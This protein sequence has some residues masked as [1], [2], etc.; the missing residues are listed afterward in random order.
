MGTFIGWLFGPLWVALFDRSQATRQATLLWT[1]AVAVE[2]QFPLVPFLEAL[3]DEAGGRWR[4]KV[5]GLADLISAGVSIPDALEAIPGILPK[6]AVA[7]VRVGAR[8]GNMAGALREAATLARRRSENTGMRFQGTLL[9]LCLLFMVLGTITTFVMIW[10]IPKY[11]AIFEGFDAKLPALTETV[12]HVSDLAGQYWFLVI[13]FPLALLGMWVL[14]AICLEALGWGPAWN[15]P[16]QLANDLWPRLKSPHILRCLSVA[17]DAG[18]PLAEA[19]TTVATR[20]PDKEF[21]L[22][23]KDLAAAVG[24][25]DDCWKALRAARMLR[26]G[27]AALLESAQRVGNLVWALR[28]MADGIERRSEYRFQFFMEFLHPA[29]IIAVGS[30]VGT[31]C[32]AMFLPL[33]TLIGQLSG[34][35]S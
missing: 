34:R 10:I 19:L 18:R 14:M 13:L 25:G 3:A 16:L 27:E 28:G 4:W 17:V 35:L 29:L 24:R 9:Y 22:R 8:T 20:H 2:K 12:I 11:K 26:Q 5:R 23:V 31:F 32:I 7:L 30:I 6:D 33:L 15:R 1:L 21:R